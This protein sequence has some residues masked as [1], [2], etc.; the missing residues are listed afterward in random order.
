LSLFTDLRK[1][2]IYVYCARTDD[3]SIYYLCRHFEIGNKQIFT[4][5]YP[6]FRC[7]RSH[8]KCVVAVLSTVARWYLPKKKQNVDPSSY[9]M[10]SRERV[11][12][13]KY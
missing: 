6:L 9:I 7:I 13:L 8:K 10:M 12:V 4:L 5:R 11:L 3:S 2:I 1:G